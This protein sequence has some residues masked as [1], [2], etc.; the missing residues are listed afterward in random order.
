MRFRPMYAGTNTPNFLHAALDK[1]ACAPFFKERR[2]KFVEPIGF[3]RKFGAMG[4]PSRG[5]ERCRTC[6][7]TREGNIAGRLTIQ[8]VARDDLHCD[9]LVLALTSHGESP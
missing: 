9:L 2:R 3:N 8:T 7:L 5:E 6:S 4:H 1:S